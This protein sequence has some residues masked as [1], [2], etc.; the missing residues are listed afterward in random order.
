MKSIRFRLLIAMLAVLLGS[1]IAKSQTSEDAPPA[2]PMGGHAHGM[3]MWSGDDMEHFLAAKLNLSEDQK[4]QA[5]ALLQKEHPTMQPLFQQQHQLDIQLRQF[6]EG[7][8]DE[9]KVQALAAQKAQVQ[10]Q[11]TINQTRIHNEVYQLLTPDQKEQL[12]QLEAQRDAHIEQR[13][14]HHAHMQ[15]QSEQ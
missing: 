9:A 1:A 11:I 15:P 10:Q 12:K 2:P 5:V 3:P 14:Q 4:K 13:M 7:N 6:V 8:Y